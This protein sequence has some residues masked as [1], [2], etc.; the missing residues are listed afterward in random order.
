MIALL[1]VESRVV[2]LLKVAPVHFR[3]S[4][5]GGGI[6][7]LTGA[8]RRRLSGSLFHAAKTNVSTSA[9]YLR[10]ATHKAPPTIFLHLGKASSS[11]IEFYG[12]VQCETAE[13][14]HDFTMK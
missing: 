11:R 7:S 9:P 13:Y 10:G 4:S 2:N 5:R 3:L 6:K 14:G 1:E 12:T 8:P